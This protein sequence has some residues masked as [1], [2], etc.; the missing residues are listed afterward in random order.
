MRVRKQV[1]KHLEYLDYKGYK[2]KIY[3]SSMIPSNYT[4]F[5]ISGG[6]WFP[7]RV[8]SQSDASP[9]KLGKLATDYIDNFPERLEDKFT[10]IQVSYA[11]LKYYI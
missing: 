9:E 6:R 10:K 7:L 11:A 3:R 5:R 1:T 8:M 4:I 2:I